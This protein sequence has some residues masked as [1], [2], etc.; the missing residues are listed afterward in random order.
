MQAFTLEREVQDAS[1]A[2][3]SEKGYYVGSVLLTEFNIDDI[4]DFYVRQKVSLDSCDIL[5]SVVSPLDEGTVEVSSVVNRMLKHID[6][7]L[8]YSFKTL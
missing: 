8:S 1:Y 3:Q 6:C 7:K 2:E 4:N 5:V